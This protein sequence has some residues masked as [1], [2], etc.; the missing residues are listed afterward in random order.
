MKDK[1]PD[2]TSANLYHHQSYQRA[3]KKRWITK[4]NGGPR[5]L[6]ESEWAPKLNIYSIPGMELGRFT[7]FWVLHGSDLCIVSNSRFEC[8]FPFFVP[9]W[10]WQTI[11]AGESTDSSVRY[12]AYAS[13]I[14]TILLTAHRYVAY[15]SDIG[16]SFRPVAHPNLVRSAYGISWAYIGGDVFHEGYKAYLRQKQA[17]DT[18]TD[19][20][21][22]PIALLP[23]KIP[24][25]DDFKTVAVNRAVF[26]SLASMGLPAFTIHT[27][28]RYSGRAMKNVKNPTLRTWGPISV[29]FK[30]IVYEY[31]R[32]LKSSLD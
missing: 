14:R 32:S 4:R 19:K 26:Q 9:N 2:Q 3:Y 25:I 27:I 23:R 5:W 21:L 20:N 28:V 15:T 30:L 29:S 24:A 12:A 22:P 7:Y 31:N 11:R 10:N 8:C 17:M 13:R 1:S 16:E 18:Q 6:R